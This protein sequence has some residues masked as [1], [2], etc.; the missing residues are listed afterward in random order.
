MYVL[1]HECGQYEARNPQT[2]DGEFYAYFNPNV[3][4]I[5]QAVSYLGG[6]DSDYNMIVEQC[7]K[8]G[9]IIGDY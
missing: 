8:D 5:K 2:P 1:K 7:K 4:S 9:Y 3:S 6:T